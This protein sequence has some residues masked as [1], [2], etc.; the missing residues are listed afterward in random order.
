MAL[1]SHIP[2]I[3]PDPSTATSQSAGRV[4]IA[5]HGTLAEPYVFR[6]LAG[7]LAEHDVDMVAPFHGHRGTDS[8]EVSA[9]EIA[10]AIITLPPAVSRV[11]V[12]GHSSGARIAL[13]ALENPRARQRVHTLV[14]LGAAWRGTND[15]AWYRPDWLVRRVLGNSYVELEDV[16]EPVAPEGVE[17]VSIA[18]RADKV[19]SANSAVAL[20]QVVMLDAVPHGALPGCTDQVLRAVGL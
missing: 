12:V 8:L 4:V 11:D 15:R 2:R 3:F 10:R 7:A 5:V 6:L 14:G 16:A 17:V 20:G 13:Q 1:L 19:V 9:A 18:S